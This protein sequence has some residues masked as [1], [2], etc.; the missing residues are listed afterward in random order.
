MEQN[1]VAPGDFQAAASQEGAN[2]RVVTAVSWDDGQIFYLSYGWQKDAS[3]TYD[4]Q[5]EITNIDGVTG[6][7][8]QLANEGYIITATGGTFAEG[9]VPRGT[10]VVV[11]QLR[12][13]CSSYKYLSKTKRYWRN[14]DMPLLG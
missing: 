5:V 12:V 9:I 7:A 13:Q 6:V 11:I 4:V 10:R 2:G 14:R 1:R 8:Q 3:T